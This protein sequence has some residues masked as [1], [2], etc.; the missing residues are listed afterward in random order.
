MNKSCLTSA[1]ERGCKLLHWCLRPRSQL[2]LQTL[3]HNAPAILACAEKKI[4]ARI[5]AFGFAAC[6][7]SRENK[8]MFSSKCWNPAMVL[9]EWPAATQHFLGTI[10]SVV[11]CASNAHQKT[12]VF[13]FVPSARRFR[14]IFVHLYSFWASGPSASPENGAF[15]ALSIDL[16]SVVSGIA[17]TILVHQS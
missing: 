16:N 15:F 6:A 1:P 11:R 9:W 2:H 3:G 17:P 14:Q 8:I 12:S 13:A 10:F 7:R 5:P 4:N